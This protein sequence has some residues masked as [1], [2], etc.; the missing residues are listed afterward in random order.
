MEKIWKDMHW[1]WTGYLQVVD[2]SEMIFSLICMSF[3][4]KNTYFVS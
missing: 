4:N 2:P 1:A 3:Q